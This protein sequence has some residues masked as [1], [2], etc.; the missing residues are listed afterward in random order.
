MQLILLR[1]GYTAGNLEKRYI[2]ST[3]EPLC[4]EGRRRLEKA[5]VYK[6][7]VKVYSSPMKRALQTAHILFP[8]AQVQQVKDL[9]E[10]DFGVFEGRTA[11]EMEEDE[12][13]RTW[14]DS[15]CTSP[16]P[17]GEDMKGF[18]KRICEV[19]KNIVAQA[20]GSSE[21]SIII[22][23]HGGSIMSIMDAFAVPKRSYYSWHT[24]NGGGY[25]TQLSLDGGEPVLS[26]CTPLEVPYI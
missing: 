24:E 16:C 17:G 9:S 10:M 1:H 2:G 4:D 3:D 25:R 6:D 14:V 21:N 7:A 11:S 13:Y 20:A 22:V 26:D 5:G 8:N 18:S 15:G 12:E 19:F 23:A